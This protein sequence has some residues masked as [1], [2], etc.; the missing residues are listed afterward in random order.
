MAPRDRILT[1]S[2]RLPHRTPSHGRACGRRGAGRWACNLDRVDTLHSTV[3]L[4]GW[5]ETGRGQGVDGL[6][7]RGVRWMGCGRLAA[8]IRRQ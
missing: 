6:A 3:E 7:H 8:P 5:R 1:V 4:V 2:P